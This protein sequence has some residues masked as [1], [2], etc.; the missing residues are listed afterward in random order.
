MS[1]IKSRED[2]DYCRAG[3]TD[4]GV[5]AIGNVISLNI[6]KL[7]N[8]NELEADRINRLLPED[9]RIIDQKEVDS[10]FSARYNCI[11][12]IYKY[13]FYKELMNIELMKE[14]TNI[15]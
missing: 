2:C 8:I 12:R 9:I 15:N 3:R 5:S 14:V 11:K 1:L 10:K 6:R 13:Y 4:K 7:Q